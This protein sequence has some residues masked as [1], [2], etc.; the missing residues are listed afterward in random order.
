M[1][2]PDKYTNINNL[3][4]TAKEYRSERDEILDGVFNKLK[5]EAKGT[6][7]EL[8]PINKRAIAILC[9]KKFGGSNYKLSIFLASC[10]E[11]RSFGKYLWW[12]LKQK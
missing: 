7:W 1:K 9:N 6:E 10:K 3:V 2:I 5:E 12:F 4:V 8:V 11:K